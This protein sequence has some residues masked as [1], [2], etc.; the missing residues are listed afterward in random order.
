MLLLRAVSEAQLPDTALLPI[1]YDYNYIENDTALSHLKSFILESKDSVSRPFRILHIGDSHVK[2]GYYA[3]TFA[4]LFDSIIRNYTSKVI[5][6]DSDSS[7]V[8]LLVMAKNGAMAK[9]ILQSVY[10][11]TIVQNFNPDLVIVSLGTN[12]AY[13]HV[14]MDTIAWYQEVLI[15]QI[16]R[17]AP[18]C[19]VLLTTPGDGLKRYYQ[20]VRI[21]KKRR[22]YKKVVHF[23]VN[24]YLV[25]VIDYYDHI[26]ERM[27]VAVWNFYPV[28]G[29]EEAIR[30]W[31]RKG[32]AQGD[33]IHL[34]KIGYQLQA[35]LLME[36]IMES[37]NGQAIKE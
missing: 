16:F 20:K 35:R 27:D 1:N 36:A 2:S 29:G 5:V 4:R 12:E 10:V 26:P 24:D 14:S 8:K 18:D 17:D 32:Y 23:E 25:D 9:T 7:V 13:N 30:E 34:T 15:E 19:D 11:D 21:S 33:M 3:E 31:N 22:R 28:M 6:H 37:V